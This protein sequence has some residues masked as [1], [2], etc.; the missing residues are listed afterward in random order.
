[1]KKIIMVLSILFLLPLVQAVE[2]LGPD[3]SAEVIY[4]NPYPIEPGQEVIL[5]VEISNNGNEPV[6]D[7]VLDLKTTENFSL[8]ESSKKS[9]DILHVDQTRIVKYKMFVDSSAN[10]GTYKIPLYIYTQGET[11]GLIKYLD[12]VVEG[13]PQLTILDVSTQ[14]NIKPGSQSTLLI[15]VKNIGSGQV[16]KAT[17]TFSSDSD[18]IKPVFSQGISYI[19]TIEPG[20]EKEFEFTAYIDSSAEFG[21]YDSDINITYEDESGNSLSENFDIGVLVSGE[22]HLQIIKTD[23]DLEDSELEIEIINSG[24][25][26]AIALQA[27]LLINNQTI[28]VDYITQVKIDKHATIK[29]ALPSGNKGQ[30]KLKY[31]GPDNQQFEQIEDIVWSKPFSFP[32]WL[33]AVIVLIIAYIVYK[34]RLWERFLK[35]KKK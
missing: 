3:V 28:D 27:G 35:K 30:L 34:K 29:F 4:S 1:M 24:S 2:T 17:A 26:K 11:A 32:G 18:Y 9:I 23:I 12:L 20:E 21:S 15:T 5:S 10:S 31:K 19:G 22:P 8:L 13:E 25:A 16:K 6:K 33:K 14:G 7:L